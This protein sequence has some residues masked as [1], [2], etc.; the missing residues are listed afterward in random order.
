[1]ITQN[2]LENLI[3]SATNA[4]YEVDI[5]HLQL[6]TWNAG[7]DTHNPM[8]LP[9]GFSAVYIF[10]YPNEYLK[11]GQAGQNSAPRYLSH[12]YYTTAPSTLAKSILN[13]PVYSALLGN[14]SPSDWIRTNTTRYN[15]LIP[16][17]YNDHFVN[18]TEAF[19]ILKCN[20]RFEG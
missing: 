17:N 10:K 6:I 7:I 5:R 8:A 11:V 15:I 16:N 1:M 3:N 2:D 12:H 20:P 9:V 18:F 13:D 19:F 14:L 4:G